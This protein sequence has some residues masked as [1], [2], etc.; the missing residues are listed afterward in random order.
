MKTLDILTLIGTRLEGITIAN[1]YLTDL[2]ERVE[3]FDDLDSEYSKASLTFR[4]ADTELFGL[5]STYHEGVMPVE[6]EAIVFGE[7]VLQLGCHAIA[8]ILNAVAVDPTWSGKAIDTNLKERFK[9][10]ETKGKKAIRVGVTIEVVYRFPR[11]RV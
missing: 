11:W 3:Y 2:G 1:G 10:V 9:S 8:D 6:I 5:K 4:D 7:N